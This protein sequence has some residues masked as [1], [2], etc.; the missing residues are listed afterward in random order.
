[1]DLKLG[2]FLPSEERDRLHLSSAGASQVK[3]LERDGEAGIKATLECGVALI[4]P[5]VYRITAKPA[6]MPK[7]EIQKLRPSK[8][9]RDNEGRVTVERRGDFVKLMAGSLDH[10]EY[11]G[12]VGEV[13]N[14]RSDASGGPMALVEFTVDESDGDGKV[15]PVVQSPCNVPIDCLEVVKGKG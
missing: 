4:Y 12:Q 7:R 1:V 11:I 14:V 13:L 2:G 6:A 8:R 3:S 15:H 5:I 10:P 9:T